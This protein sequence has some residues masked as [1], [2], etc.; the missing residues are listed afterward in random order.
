MII[1][2]NLWEEH[3]GPTAVALGFFDGV[4]IGHRAVVRRAVAEAKKKGLVPTVFTFASSGFSPVS[5]KNLTLLQ[6]ESQKDTILEQEGI[7]QIVRPDF[8]QFRDLPAGDFFLKAL[9]G[10]LRAKVLV[11]GYNYHFGKEAGGNVALLHTLA[12]QNGIEV[13]ALPPVEWEGEPVS[14]TR[15]RTAVREGRIEQ[16]NAMLGSPFTLALEVVHGRCLGRTMN[17]PTINQLIPERYTVP[18]FGVYYSRVVIDGR[19]YAGVTNIGVKPTVDR[20]AELS[21]ETHIL[22]FSGDLY[23]QIVSVALLR[24]LRPERRFESI[25]AL[26]VRIH[27][28]VETVREIFSSENSMEK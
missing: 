9:I 20:N 14:S 1:S 17:S 7:R 13:F 5:K 25:D 24:F 23:G 3:S 4:H 27:Q 10:S 6:T 8:S 15:I 26:S 2:S 18:R 28:D 12:E 21:C 22:D 16:A 11:C 19:A